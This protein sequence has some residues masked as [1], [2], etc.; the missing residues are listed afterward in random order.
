[1]PLQRVLPAEVLRAVLADHASLA[2]VHR[3][4]VS[5]M[6]DSAPTLDL[7][8]SR[9][10]PVVPHTWGA[11]VRLPGAALWRHVRGVELQEMAFDAWTAEVVE[12]DSAI[13]PAADRVGRRGRDRLGLMVMIRMAIA[14]RPSGRTVSWICAVCEVWEAVRRH[15]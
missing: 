3:R 15:G 7:A 12:D 8:A 9:P 11:A 14:T 5:P 6:R 2:E 10:G 1:M 4:D 13:P